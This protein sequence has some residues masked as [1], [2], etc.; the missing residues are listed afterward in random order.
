[1]FQIGPAPFLFVDMFFS[2]CACGLILDV[3]LLLAHKIFCSSFSCKNRSLQC[4]MW[5]WA[6]L[7][8]DYLSRKS[9]THITGKQMP[10]WYW[11]VLVRMRCFC[12]GKSLWTVRR[13][14][15][16]IIW[17]TSPFSILDCLSGSQ[18]QSAALESD[19]A[20]VWSVTWPPE[21][22]WPVE[23]E[24]KGDPQY[25]SVCFLSIY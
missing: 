9:S 17:P 7:L 25:S 8:L 5:R 13:I 14:L 11:G 2:W 19:I 16:I 18:L 21:N 23:E 3:L 24:M 6:I 12:A 22:T 1:M 10:C 4:R 20:A 15:N